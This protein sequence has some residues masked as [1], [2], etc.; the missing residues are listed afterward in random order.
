[1]RRLTRNEARR[2][3]VRAQLLDADRP[4]DLAG[5]V[6]RLTFLQLDPTAVVA[7]SADFIAWSRLGSAYAPAQLQLA[8]E[9]DRTL[10]E[11]SSQ[12]SAVDAL[13][14]MVRPMADLGLFLADMAALPSSGTQRSDWLRAND[15]FRRQLLELIRLSG[16][17]A[18]REIPDTSDVAWQSTG[19]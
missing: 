12:P 13:V 16:P 10:F 6:E 7:P 15:G 1:M 5:V 2:I 17:L 9:R 3:A 11:H 4:R 19:W 18:S 8:L 14:A